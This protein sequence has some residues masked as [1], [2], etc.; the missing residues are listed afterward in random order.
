MIEPKLNFF[1]IKMEVRV[2]NASVMVEPNLGI[3]EETLDTVDVGSSTDVLL[4][5]VGDL[6]VLPT[7]GKD[8]ISVILVGI[9][10]ASP[11]RVLENEGKKRSLSPIGHREG[12]NL[13]VSLI[14][15]KYHLLPFGSPTPL[16]LSS[17]TKEGFIHFQFPREGLHLFKR[18][19]IDGFPGNP[20]DLLSRSKATG[21]VESRPV[22]GNAQAEKIEKMSDF[23]ERDA[24]S[25]KRGSGEIA[26]RIAAT[27]APEPLIAT[28]QFPFFTPGANPSSTPS[29]LDKKSPTFWQA[30]SQANRLFCKH[31][32]IVSQYQFFGYYLILF[33][34][35]VN[36]QSLPGTWRS[37]SWP[38]GHTWP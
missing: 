36:L 38:P 30:G 27:G 7:G 26:E 6:M 15:P 37:F 28:P 32:N 31:K 25:L 16:S 1:E 17:S 33:P 10:D 23:V 5:P 22:C 13:T 19:I 29:E 2:G 18:C 3:G 34:F 11:L 4:F 12:N 24:N 8:S 35:P 20:K 14:H 9:I 21:E